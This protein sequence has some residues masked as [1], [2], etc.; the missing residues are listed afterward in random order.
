MGG[1]GSSRGGG[2]GHSGGSFGGGHSGHS[3]G[4]S[5]SS[6][7]FG[8]SR[9][10]GSSSG[11][12]SSNRGS[13]SSFGGFSS[14][15]GTSSGGFGNRPPASGP[16]YGGG[17]SFGAPPPPG[18]HRPVYYNG[19]RVYRGNGAG[20]GMGCG[21][22]TIVFVV[23]AFVFIFI[24]ASTFGGIFS[25]GTNTSNSG[26]TA[27]TIQR[28]A[29]P[30]DAVN[31]TD[32]YEDT[33]GLITDKAEMNSG[34]QYFL[35]K[36]GVQPYIY[37]TDNVNGSHDPTDAEYAAFAH[38]LYYS[39]FTDEAHML[40]IFIWYDNDYYGYI[41]CGDQAKTVVDD[42]A[43][44][45]LKSYFARYINY[46]NISYEEF[47]TMSFTDTADRMMTVTVSPWIYV[48]IVAGVI[49]LVVIG[50]V[51]WR[52]AKKQKNLEAK[53]TEDMLNTPLEKFGDKEAEDLG[54]KYDDDPNNDPK[55]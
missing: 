39:E 5:R 11:G 43:I 33:L 50:F 10:S 55:P 22:A 45:I 3:F 16:S 8:S 17:P 29:L 48:L 2:G 32:F 24:L 30:D 41:D 6:G 35:D 28:E 7:G 12:F 40:V 21:A 36:T 26:I 31:K 18:Y 34:L 47:F 53:Q 51:W 52:H 38:D 25:G 9:S 13:G 20:R 14:N 27:S 37:L 19:G 54:K 44:E 49:L 42:E 15:R 4:G 1:F 46:Q 23:I